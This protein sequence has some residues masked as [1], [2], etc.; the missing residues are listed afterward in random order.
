MGRITNKAAFSGGASDVLPPADDE[1]M[2]SALE[3]GDLPGLAVAGDTAQG[4]VISTQGRPDR[5]VKPAAP[6]QRLPRKFRKLDGRWYHDSTA[7]GLE[8]G[9][10]RCKV[11]VKD[12]PATP[13]KRP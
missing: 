3:T 6:P 7:L 12:Q 1:D 11:P 4:W 2:A 8:A 5:G 9:Q 13:S 10:R